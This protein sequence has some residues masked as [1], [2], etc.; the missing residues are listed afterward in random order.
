MIIKDNSKNAESGHWYTRTG[1]P[2]YTTIGKNG[3]ER[4]TTLRDARTENLVPSVTTIIKCASSQGLEVWKQQQVLLASLTLPRKA[5]EPETDWIERIMQDSKETGRKAAERGTAIH[6]SVQNYY[7]NKPIS[8]YL[9][10]AKE[11][12]KAIDSHFGKQLWLAEESFGSELGY[13][14]KCDLVSKNDNGFVVDVKT[15]EFTDPEA[16]KGYDEHLMQLSAYRMGFNLPKAR[17]AN[18]FVS[19]QSPVKVKIVEWSEEDLEKGWKMFQ[20]LLTFWQVKNNHK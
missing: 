3:K 11:T 5:T 6:A 16:I 13:G 10:H 8:E 4:N 20:S 19:V 17:C 15:K 7:E 12:E 18:I 9:E 14:G 1:K 2:A